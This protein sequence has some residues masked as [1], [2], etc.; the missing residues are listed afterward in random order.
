MVFLLK[1]LTDVNDKARQVSIKVS[2]YANWNDSR[3]ERLD[4]K[5]QQN[6][7]LASGK[8]VANFYVPDFYVYN[9]LDFQQSMFGSEPTQFL[10]LTPEGKRL[11]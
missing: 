4:M 9:L 2:L 6:I 11:S 10:L 3:I 7:N 1:E 5:S 8:N